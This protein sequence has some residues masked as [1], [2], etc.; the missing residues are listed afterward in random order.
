MIK[1]LLLLTCLLATIHTMGQTTKP[2]AKK[3]A[4]ATSGKRP[5]KL[6]STWGNFLS[7]SL[8]KNELVKLID[9]ALIVRD[10]KGAKYPVISF[11]FTYETREAYLNDTTGQ[12]GLYK[13][14]IGNNFQDARMDSVWR[15]GMKEKLEKGNVLYFDEI[16]I[17]Y[18]A[19]KIYKAPALKFIVR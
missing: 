16:L 13:D 17:Q 8:P 11:A 1:H 10:E 7:D 3:P 5:T 19:D 9:S 18:S 14:Y 2:A 12:P 15:K 4:A 6:V